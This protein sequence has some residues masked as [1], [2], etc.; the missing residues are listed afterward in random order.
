MKPLM[1]ALP[2]LLVIATPCFSLS[3][4][5]FCA[6]LSDFAIKQNVAKG[7]M[8]DAITRNEGMSVSCDT[9]IVDFKKSAALTSPELYLRRSGIQKQWNQHYC[10]N[11][12][13]TP[14]FAAGWSAS[15]TIAALDGKSLTVTAECR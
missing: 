5:E 8:I 15:T 13:W 4:A 3:E 6:L 7:E 10:T 14:I 2:L 12:E 11:K 1:Y 9:K